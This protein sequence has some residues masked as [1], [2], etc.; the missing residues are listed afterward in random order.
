MGLLSYVHFQ[1]QPRIESVFAELKPDAQVPE[2]L[3]GRL[4]FYR[5]RRKWMATLC[6]FLVITS[7][8]LGLQVFGSFKPVI[9]I[10]LVAAAALFALKANKTLLRFGWF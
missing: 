3:A 2:K 10:I 7:I 6:L 9:N 1:L 8:I 4:K 5:V